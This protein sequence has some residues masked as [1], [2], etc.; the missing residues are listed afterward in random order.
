MPMLIVYTQAGAELVGSVGLTSLGGH[1]AIAVLGGDRDRYLSWV[2]SVGRGGLD[3]EVD[4]FAK[5]GWS[6]PVYR[7][8]I[9]TIED[10]VTSGMSC[11][12]ALQW[13]DKDFYVEAQAYANEWGLDKTR[14]QDYRQVL[15]SKY[16]CAEIVRK[17]LLAAGGSA[18]NPSWSSASLPDTAARLASDLH[19]QVGDGLQHAHQQWPAE[20]GAATFFRNDPLR[21]RNV[22]PWPNKRHALARQ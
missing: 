16:N 14:L 22:L 5:A 6:D 21:G 13:W 18:Y 8:Q 10:G 2:T 1:A 9:P 12:A 7:V 3:Y 15:S 11:N 4:H 17:I 19:R 20:P